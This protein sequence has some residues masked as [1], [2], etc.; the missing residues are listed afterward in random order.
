MSDLHVFTDDEEMV[1]AEDV[2]DAL[3]VMA[4]HAGGDVW[5]PSTGIEI[6]QMPDDA[7]LTIIDFDMVTKRRKT[8]GE[9]AREKGRGY[10][11][12]PVG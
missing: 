2:A 5:N 6:E 11:C 4:E 1:V 12:G 3:A 9:W 8:A 10:L 7:M